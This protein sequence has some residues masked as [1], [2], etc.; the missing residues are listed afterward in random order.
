MIVKISFETACKEFRAAPEDHVN[1]C[2][3]LVGYI[4]QTQYTS[5]KKDPL[6]KT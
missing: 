1:T 6:E 5:A 3:L 4:Y 2:V